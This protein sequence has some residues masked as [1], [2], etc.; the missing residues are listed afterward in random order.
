LSAARDDHAAVLGRGEIDVAARR[1]RAQS[2]HA[3]P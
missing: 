2:A 1:S 3:S